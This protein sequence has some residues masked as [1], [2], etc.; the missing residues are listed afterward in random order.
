[1]EGLKREERKELEG[2]KEEGGERGDAALERGRRS[3]KKEKKREAG[4][5]RG[6]DTE[7]GK[8]ETEVGQG[9]GGIPGQK[10][11]I[12]SLCL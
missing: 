3:W 12:Q 11:W 10:Q 7:K 8:E 2:G 5:G 4:G 6:N 1:L 9:G